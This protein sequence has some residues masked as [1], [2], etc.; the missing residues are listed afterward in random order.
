M[1]PSNS[2]LWLILPISAAHGLSFAVTAYKIYA[3]FVWMMRQLK[4]IRKARARRPEIDDE[5]DAPEAHEGLIATGIKQEHD[6][7]ASLGMKIETVFD[8]RRVAT[9]NSFERIEDQGAL[10]DA[11]KKD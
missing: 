1:Y 2:L 5:L 8:E 9:V 10:I 4:T 3:S 6:I 7:E 11:M